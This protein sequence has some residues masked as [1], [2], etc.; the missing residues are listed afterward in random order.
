MINSVLIIKNISHENPGLILN[1]LKEFNINF[2]IIDLSQKL[3]FPKIDEFSLIII[4]GGPDSA[5][6]NS[7][8]ISKELQ[9]I[10]LAFEKKIPIL[11]ICLGLQLMV[12]AS[13]GKVYKNPID[14]KGFKHENDWYCISLTE[15]GIKDP[16]FNEV[17]E[18]FI[19]FQLHGETVRIKKDMKL[20]GTGK[21]CKNQIVRIGAFNYGFQFHFELTRE[22]LNDWIIL[23]PELR[24]KDK[25][26]IIKDYDL[27]YNTY[28][29]IGKKI[30]QN[31]L[32]L[33]H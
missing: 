28:E 20:L 30:I 33:I 25:S 29:K 26:S 22:M 32:N 9:Y 14:E 6:D 8:K 23:A 12:K 7:G 24:E 16:I 11:G 17:D 18:K 27:I 5:N 10:K 13:G 3:E 21:Y 15:E 1:V 19:T 2:E 4:M 31:Y